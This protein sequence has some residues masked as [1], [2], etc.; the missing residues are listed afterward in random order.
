MNRFC[1]LRAIVGTLALG[2][3]GVAVVN[4]DDKPTVL[5][6][7]SG[8]PVI[9][10]QTAPRM[11]AT[12]RV[13]SEGSPTF[14]ADPE[15]YRLLQEDQYFRILEVTWRAGNTDKPHTHPL[16]SVT[17]AT[18]DC[19]MLRIHNADGSVREIADTLAGKVTIVPMVTQP[20]RAEN[21]GTEDCTAVIIERK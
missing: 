12:P 9:Q 3:L 13:E 5:R 11:Q 2:A 18:S 1:L 8:Q 6:G 17:V 7:G 21:P 20:H 15:T 14:L 16:P 19:E 10:T 4:A